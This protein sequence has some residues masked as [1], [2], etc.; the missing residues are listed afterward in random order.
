MDWSNLWDNAMYDDSSLEDLSFYCWQAVSLDEVISI[1]QELIDRLID[2]TPRWLRNKFRF[3][4]Q[5]K[6]LYILHNPTSN[7]RPNNTER[8]RVLWDEFRIEL[9]VSI[10]KIK[11]NCEYLLAL[12][13]RKRDKKAA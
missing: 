4:L 2:Q 5:Q 8:I 6:S 12:H 3:E 7:K 1:H 9:K 13:S 11:D 10:Q